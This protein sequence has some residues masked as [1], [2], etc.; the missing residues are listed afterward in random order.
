MNPQEQQLK[1]EQIQELNNL[2]RQMKDVMF[3]VNVKTGNSK[4]KMVECFMSFT[5]I[6]EYLKKQ[7]QPDY[8]NLKKPTNPQDQELY[9]RKMEYKNYIE[10]LKKMLP[11]IKLHLAKAIDIADKLEPMSQ[12]KNLQEPSKNTSSKPLN[13]FVENQ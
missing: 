12:L 10:D 8:L 5:Q 13:P 9:L 6:E 7:A 1:A 3:F 11:E 2:L 4:S